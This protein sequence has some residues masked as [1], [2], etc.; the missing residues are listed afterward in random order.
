[1]N[2]RLYFVTESPASIAAWEQAHVQDARAVATMA[3]YTQEWRVTDA[4]TI[5]T[6]LALDALTAAHQ[7]L[8][9]CA[10]LIYEHSLKLLRE[11]NRARRRGARLYKWSVSYRIT[12]TEIMPEEKNLAT[13]ALFTPNQSYNRRVWS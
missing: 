2:R 13:T 4:K 9:V 3:D 10:E 1:M 6:L 12:S 8:F 5:C 11:P 7:N